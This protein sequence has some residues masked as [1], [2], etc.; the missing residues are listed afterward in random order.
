MQ[1]TLGTFSDFWT[2]GKTKHWEHSGFESLRILLPNR[3][4]ARPSA[5]GKFAIRP[6]YALGIRIMKVTI[7]K[8]HEGH[9]EDCKVALLNSKLG[10]EY[11]VT[12]EKA[13]SVL[14][15]GITQEEIFVAVD[16]GGECLGFIWFILKSAFHSF[17]YLHIIAVKEAFRGK[18]I[19]KKLLF[20]FE[21]AVFTDN[22]KVFL[23]VA[24]FNPGAKRLYES[25]G[26]QQVGVIPNLYKEGVSEYLMMKER[27]V[28][29]NGNGLAIRRQNS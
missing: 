8:A 26:Y 3:V 1:R 24:D 16:E 5:T 7:I 4:H 12:E 20:F 9:L 2:V 15:E 6:G 22:S 18:G 10:Q 21:E 14:T 29:V 19:G 28:T 27:K 13:L 17:P 23:V 25:L 11:F